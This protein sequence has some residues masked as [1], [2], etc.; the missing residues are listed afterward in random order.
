MGKVFDG[1]DDK[2][3]AWIAR[4]Q[5]FFVGTAPSGDGGHVNVSPKG[6]IES[7]R[8]FAPK[9]IGYIDLI[10]SGSE[11][12]AHVRENGRIVIML[13][14]FE[15]PPR[16]VRVYGRGEVLQ[17]GDPRF[18]EAEAEFDLDS[19]P[20]A[21]EAAR[22]IV[23]VDVDR[24]ADSCG[25]GVPLMRYEGRRPQQLAWIDRKLKQGGRDALIE[26]AVEHNAAS[27]DGL[28]ALELE[29]L[30]RSAAA[31]EG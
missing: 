22:G 8:I 2:L 7:L 4:Q 29:T 16:I 15:G 25:Y 12:V 31:R 28:P 13:C 23:I 14:S 9:R 24:V 10:G 26:Y 17:I 20:A 11:T 6:P 21:V 3:A 1:I 19:V 27:I 30:P 18:R 5:M